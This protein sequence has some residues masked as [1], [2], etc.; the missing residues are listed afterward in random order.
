MLRVHEY[1]NKSLIISILLLMIC[2]QSFS[3]HVHFADGDDEHPSHAHAHTLG[4][5]HAD[6]LVTEHHDEASSD[7]LGTLSKQ[8]LA[9][10]FL[11]SVL[12][13]I[14]IVSLSNSRHWPSFREKRPRHHL[15][16]FRPPLR[17]PPL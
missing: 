15:L 9:L 13:A 3:T 10:D 5:M 14:V 12:L 17:A 4:S 7:I 2:V 1:R 6:H 16:F 8:S 11:V